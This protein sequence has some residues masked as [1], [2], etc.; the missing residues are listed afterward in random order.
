MI[1]VCEV[2]GNRMKVF[3]KGD[4]YTYGDSQKVCC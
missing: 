4:S 3:A 1:K 2:C